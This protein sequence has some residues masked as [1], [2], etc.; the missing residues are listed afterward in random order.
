MMKQWLVFSALAG[1]AAAVQAA[2]QA[3]PQ[4]IR[5]DAGGVELELVDAPMDPP[6]EL[7]YRPQGRCQPE[8]AITRENDVTTARHIKSCHGAGDYEGTIFTLRMSAQTSFEL[9]LTAGGITLTGA[10]LENYRDM[11]FATRVGGISGER[12]DLPWEK[13]RKWLVGAEAF[14]QRA[15]GCCTLAIRVAY[16][17]ISVR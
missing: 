17:G 14:A 4:T 6:F 13:R 8:V 10:G 3:A 12:P 15:S 5:I 11:R 16:G 9:E 1:S 7:T 2:P